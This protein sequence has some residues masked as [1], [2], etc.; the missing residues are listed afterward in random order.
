M[1]TVNCS[2]EFNDK[3]N[4]I[5]REVDRNVSIADELES[6]K[7]DIE[8]IKN[9]IMD[10]LMFDYI[11][12]REEQNYIESLCFLYGYDRDMFFF[13][14]T[15]ELERALISKGY[16]PDIVCDSSI[17]KK[18]EMTDREDKRLILFN[19]SRLFPK[20]IKDVLARATTTTNEI[21][22]DCF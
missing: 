5:K 10:N 3:S 7:I 15:L 16:D 11:T 4:S 13:N 18:G 14:L 22:E 19:I 6:L 2:I 20:V 8:N 9:I 12:L 17:K 21:L 1:T